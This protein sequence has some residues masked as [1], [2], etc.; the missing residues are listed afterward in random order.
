MSL[1]AGFPGT[2][3]LREDSDNCF[4]FVLPCRSGSL[5]SPD[6]FDDI[7]GND[8]ETVDSFSTLRCGGKGR[9]SGVTRR[10]SGYLNISENVG[11]YR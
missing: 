2:I 1:N 10:Y 3:E 7:V 9:S 4:S 11:V 6:R 8:P 5:T